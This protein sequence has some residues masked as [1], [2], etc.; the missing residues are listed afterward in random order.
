VTVELDPAFEYG[1]VAFEGTA[2]VAAGRGNE[3]DADGRR[4]E[5]GRL[6]YLGRDRSEL[7]LSAGEDG[8]RLLLFGGV[9]FEAPITMWWNFVARTRDEID[10]ANQDWRSGGERFG[11]PGSTLARVP[12]PDVP[13]RRA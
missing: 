7:R 6:A 3:P 11:D 1:V 2:E 5:P 13:W 4:V 12:S 9:P 10:E 8:T